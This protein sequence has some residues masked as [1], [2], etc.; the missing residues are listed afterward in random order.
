[1][2]SCKICC[3]LKLN[4]FKM[5]SELIFLTG[6]ISPNQMTHTVII[7]P[8]FRKEE[9]LR[10]IDFYLE[11]TTSRVLFVE[12]SGTDLSDEI[13]QRVNYSDRLQ[14]ITYDQPHFDRNLGKGFGEMCILDYA[15]NNSSFF[16]ESDFIFK[17]TGR[18]I[19]KN[20]NSLL[21]KVNRVECD[22]Y[23]DFLSG[24]TYID[25]RFW[26]AKRSF[27]EDYLLKSNIKVND[28]AGVFF[29]HILARNIHKAIINGYNFSPYLGFPNYSGQ[30]GS[31]GY[32][33][34][35]PWI[36]WWMRN[37]KTKIKRHLL[38]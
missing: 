21:H 34:D 9:Y 36:I 28:G 2:G 10:S 13:N 4:F 11:N 19:I 31:E 5:S 8:N 20:I 1:M 7:D 27:Y 3:T 26:G 23:A 24:L 33:L 38:V 6:C 29:E 37:L 15:K 14:I 35:S 16:N 18:Y 17:I 22:I 25:S 30:S 32:Y 12:N